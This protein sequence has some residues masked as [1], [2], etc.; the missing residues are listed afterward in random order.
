MI[1]TAPTTV[2]NPVVTAAAPSLIA[3]LQSVQAFISNLGT[4]PLQIPVKFPGAL[5]VLIGTVEMQAPVL[6]S[7]E[8]T[9][10]QNEAIAKISGWITTLQKDA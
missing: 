4:D 5:Q 1:T 2:T 3:V 8:F 6:A 7:A 10:L 9:T